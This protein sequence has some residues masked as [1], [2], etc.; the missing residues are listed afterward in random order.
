[1]GAERNEHI[2]PSGLSDQVGA[3]SHPQVCKTGSCCDKHPNCFQ[4]C[5]GGFA[6]LRDAWHF[7]QLRRVALEVDRLGTK[8]ILNEERLA[9]QVFGCNGEIMAH[10]PVSKDQFR[11]IRSAIQN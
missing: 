5:E 6:A 3:G 7:Q 9:V 1:M 10:L 8:A 4:G 2:T 11:E